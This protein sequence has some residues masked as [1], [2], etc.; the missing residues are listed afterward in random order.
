M[1]F[2]NTFS[3]ALLVAVRVM[4]VGWLWGEWLG[5]RVQTGWWDRGARSLFLGLL[6]NLAIPVLLAPFGWWSVALDWLGWGLLL[7]LGLWGNLRSDKANGNWRQG[8][9]GLLGMTLLT[10]SVLL[11]PH[12]SEWLAGGWDPGVYQ[13]N[14]VRIAED[15]GI[16]DR[17][18][19]IYAGMTHEEITWFSRGSE[20]YREIMPSVPVLRDTGDL[21]LYY[22]HLTPICG[23]WLFRLGGMDGL[24][25]MPMLLGFWMLWVAWALFDRLGASGWR[26]GLIMMA[27]VVSSLWWYHQAIPTTEMLYTL[28][29]LGGILF[30]LSSLRMPVVAGLA[31]FAA[32]V[33]HLNFPVVWALLFCVFAWT[34]FGLQGNRRV[35]RVALC[36]LA[37]AAGVLWDLF[38]AQITVVRLQEK[39][40]IL[41][42]VLG[43]FVVLGLASLFIAWKPPP[44]TVRNV[45]AHAARWGGWLAGLATMLAPLALSVL[46]LHAHWYARI[47][48]LPL[49]GMLAFRVS[50]FHLFMGIPYVVWAGWGLCLVALDREPCRRTMRILMIALG[51][52]FLSFLLKPGIAEIYPWGLRRYV[53]VALPFIAACQGMVLIHYAENW[54]RRSVAVRGVFGVLLILALAS[55][56][57]H[58][59]AAHKLGDY[60]GLRALLEELNSHLRQ[61]DVVVVDHPVWGTPLMLAYGYDVV[62]GSILW[63][64]EDPEHRSA[65]MDT[66][67]RLRKSDGR[68]VVWLTS[69]EAGLDIY[70]VN[71][72][73]C[74]PLWERQDFSY[75]T[76]IHSG[77]GS[78]F[79]MR[80]NHGIFHL[81]ECANGV[82]Q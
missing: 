81:Y 15:H 20:R 35:P 80:D 45:L 49:V 57:L 32:T 62:N 48:D 34:G 25:R 2:L 56:I 11:I 79:A 51:G 39:D 30:Y 41:W 24:L 44:A 29:L 55:G 69:T 28:L 26:A 12:R 13:N 52:V 74:A 72:E 9:M 47:A 60:L 64:S 61:G 66:L 75:R 27:W 38:F 23:A 70:G 7:A 31:F 46:M 50:R 33:N 21:P 78:H 14:A 37:V 5:S 54:R 6:I 68:R 59:R 4:S 76:V 82:P 1:H 40:Q 71:F 53:V 36:F 65:F 63:E 18:H 42:W 19:S 77:R 73:S 67:R 22:F 3:L 16:R 8:V 10:W 43:P 17:T 58:A